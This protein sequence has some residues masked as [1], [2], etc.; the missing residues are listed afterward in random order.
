ML[1]GGG[2]LC[3]E[4]RHCGGWCSAGKGLTG[5]WGASGTSMAGI[6]PGPLFRKGNNELFQ[7]LFSTVSLLGCKDSKD[8]KGSVSLPR[9]YRVVFV[10]FFLNFIFI[11]K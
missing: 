9:P 11:F 5:A 1:R 4:A 2:S 10:F 6:R 3:T 7:L 8:S